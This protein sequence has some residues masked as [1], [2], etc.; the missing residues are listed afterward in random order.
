MGEQITQTY[1]IASTPLFVFFLVCSPRNPCNMRRSPFKIAE[2]HAM[3]VRFFFALHQS[4]WI[5]CILFSFHHLF[6]LLKSP[7]YFRA[8]TFGAVLTHKSE[9]FYHSVPAEIKL[10]NWME[11]EVIAEGFQFAECRD[12]ARWMALDRS[13][14]KRIIESGV[15]SSIIKWSLWYRCIQRC[16]AD[17]KCLLPAPGR[18]S[19]D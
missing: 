15:P 4:K 11:N 18:L 3:C 14:F 5:N 2:A 17:L 12:W 1:P 7:E 19:V 9:Q 8:P 10:A 13:H 6:A 16:V